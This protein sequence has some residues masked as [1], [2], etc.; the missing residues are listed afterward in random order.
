V[1]ERAND[2]LDKLRISVGLVRH[3]ARFPRVR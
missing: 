1:G 2:G 3:R